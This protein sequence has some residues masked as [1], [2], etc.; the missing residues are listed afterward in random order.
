MVRFP[1]R[2]EGWY[3]SPEA[4]L[5]A[6]DPNAVFLESLVFD[7]D[8]E[9]DRPFA[10]LAEYYKRRKILDKSGDIAG[11]G[12]KKLINAVYGQLAQRAGWDRAKRTP[13]RSHQLEWAG[14]ITSACR[15]SVYRTARACGDK[16]ISINA[17]S[18][19]ALCPLDDIVPI[20]K[21]LGEW[22]AEE[23]EAGLFWQSG[24]YTLK[25]DGEWKKARTRGIP[26]GQYTTEQLREAIRTQ[27]PITLV[28]KMFITYSLA[29]MGQWERRNTWNEE[30]S[31]YEF[32]GGPGSKR[33][34]VVRPSHI[35]GGCGTP[36]KGLPEHMH[37]TYPGFFVITGENDRSAPH[38]LPWVDGP[39]ML[40]DQIDGYMVDLNEDTDD[41]WE[42]ESA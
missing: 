20:G 9:T 21:G 5:V 4:E 31:D 36:C 33:T 29:L 40:K 26:R 16:L 30:P 28:R 1:H 8:D 7:E 41:E 22:G 37:R 14:Y 11:Y 32:G 12:Y 42:F 23:Y 17:D 3:W 15:A 27:S 38:Y 24:I 19:Q 34:H 13:P 25:Q 2:V 18:V 35:G 6:N 39:D 10:W